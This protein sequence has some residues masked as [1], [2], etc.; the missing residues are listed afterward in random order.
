MGAA[1]L[2]LAKTMG[3]TRKQSS[4]TKNGAVMASNKS[5]IK[6]IKSKI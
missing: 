3:A 6:K 4:A 5:F 2:E 1:K